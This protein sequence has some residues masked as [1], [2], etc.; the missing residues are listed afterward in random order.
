MPEHNLIDTQHRPF[1]KICGLTDPATARACGDMGADAVGLVFFEKSP[2]FVS[3]TQA[4]EI[5]RAL[6]P[7]T[8]ATGVFVNES[9]D[10]IM[11]KVEK[12]PLQAVQLHGT[13]KPELVAKLAGKGVIVIKAVFSQKEPLLSSAPAWEKASF[14]LAECGAGK[15]PGGNAEEWNWADAAGMRTHAPVIVAGGLTPDNVRFAMEK[16]KAAGAD[17]SSGVES[18]P[19]IKDLEKVQ[20]FIQ[21]INMRD[22]GD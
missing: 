12:L 3:D 5:I 8:L 15:L 2:R 11:E 14:L 13:E 21:Q 9:Y 4:G 1:V 17:I 16:S 7:D 20:A 6:E 22:T 19:G 18:A 10:R